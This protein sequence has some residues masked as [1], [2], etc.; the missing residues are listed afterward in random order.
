MNENDAI[1]TP[2]ATRKGSILAEYHERFETVRGF[3]HPTSLVI[4]DALLAFQA[5]SNVEGPLLEIGVYYGKS[6][7]LLAMHSR[8]QEPLYLVDFSDFVDVAQRTI[9][10]VKPANVT[11]F[12]VKS[13]ASSFRQF[14]GRNARSMRWIHI[15]GDHRAETAENDLQLANLLLSNLGIICVDDFFNPRYPHL[16]YVVCRFLERHPG[17][18]RMF[19]CGFN[20]AYLVR[21]AQLERHLGYVRNELARDLNAAGVNDFTI[22]KTDSDAVI[23][24]FGI[25]EKWGDYTYHGLD[26]DPAVILM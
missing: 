4:W 18:L 21:P 6:A 12:K 7:L 26:E 9:A 3:V 17:D 19:L 16:A 24:S 2:K 8:E 25:M 15:D 14:A 5:R 1:R 10:A 13:S 20:K 11:V 23:N 22:Y